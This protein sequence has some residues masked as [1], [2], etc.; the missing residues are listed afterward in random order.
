MSRDLSFESFLRELGTRL[1]A[2]AVVLG[3]FFGLGYANRTDAFGLS[4]LFD[5]PLGFFGVAFVLL[6]L[7]SLAWIVVQQSRG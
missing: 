1:G 4:S 3:I 2:A 6:G 7:V 5:T